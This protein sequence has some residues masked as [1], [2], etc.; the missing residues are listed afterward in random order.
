MLQP[1]NSAA[2]FMSALPD[3]VPSPE[4]SP[5]VAPPQTADKLAVSLSH[6]AQLSALHDEATE[7]ALLANLWGRTPLAAGLVAAGTVFCAFWAKDQ[8]PWQSLAVWVV[9]VAGGLAAGATVFVR[10][11]RAPFM[12]DTLRVF[13]R[14]LLTVLLYGGCAWG[15]GAFLVFPLSGTPWVPLAFCAGMSAAL[16]LLLRTGAAALAFALPAVVITAT[17]FAVRPLRDGLALAGGLLLSAALAVAL[18]YAA[19]RFE[20]RLTASRRTPNSDVNP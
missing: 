5:S 4:P 1:C 13:A 3:A 7:T 11:S 18:A 8:V 19:D 10:A 6:L 12:R 14:D 15:A 20:L 9:L 16:G 17:A 2:A